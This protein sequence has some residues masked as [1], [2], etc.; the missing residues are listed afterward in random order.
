MK[1]TLMI[2]IP[3]VIIGAV[4][5]YSFFSAYNAPGDTAGA[6]YVDPQTARDWITKGK[7]LV[8][9]VQTYD[10]YLKGHFADSIPTHAYPVRTPDQIKRVESI[11]PMLKKADKPVILVCFGGVTGAP[12]ARLALIKK[13]VPNRNLY[14]LQGGTWGW[15]WKNMFVSGAN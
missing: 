2:A 7:A 6:Q 8:V 15:P 1:K 12:N 11:A 14:I 4:I 5:G 9:D 13:G 3:L 10:G